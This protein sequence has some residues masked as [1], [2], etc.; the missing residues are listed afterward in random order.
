MGTRVHAH[1]SANSRKDER[2]HEQEGSLRL[3]GTEG[4][5]GTAGHEGGAV[6]QASQERHQGSQVQISCRKERC[7]SGGLLATL[8]PLPA[9]AEEAGKLFD[10]DYTLPIMAAQFLLL[11]VVLDKTWFN[12]VGKVLDDRDEKLRTLLAGVQDNTADI[13]A[14]EDEASKLV[15]E[16]RAAAATM[17][18]DAKKEAETE[19]TE[20]LNALKKKLDAQYE[21]AMAEIDAEEVQARKDLEPEIEKLAKQIVDKVMA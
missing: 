13:T 7:H 6:H 20:K 12:P 21:S 2:G 3:C 17:I 16:A 19:G 15:N 18:A 14:K 8:D 9:H 11:M 10:F 4:G 1:R 5:C